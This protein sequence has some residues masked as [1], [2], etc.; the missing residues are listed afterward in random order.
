M[1]RYAGLFG[2]WRAATDDDEHHVYA[3]ALYRHAKQRLN[4]FLL[5][6]GRLHASGKGKWT[7][8]SCLL[9]HDAE[10]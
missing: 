8:T 4:A 1:A 3:I 2:D 9:A 10:V 5:R 6:H 7:K